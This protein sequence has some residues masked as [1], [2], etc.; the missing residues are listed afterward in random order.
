VSVETRE[1]EAGGERWEVWWQAEG[2]A[3]AGAAG[4]R[5]A[6]AG[7]RASEGGMLV[8]RSK[9]TGRMH[10]LTWAAGLDSAADVGFA[11]LLGWAQRA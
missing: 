2:V 11:N 1:F 10:Q 6:P 5:A 8:F 3:K 4:G 9:G 7:Q